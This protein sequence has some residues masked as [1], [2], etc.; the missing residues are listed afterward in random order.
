MP[1]LVDSGIFAVAKEVYGHIG[2]A[3]YGLRTTTMALSLMALLRINRPEGLK[4]HAPAELG[5]VLGLDRA[6]E[7]KT[8]RRKLGQLAALGKAEAFGRKLAERRVARRGRALGFL[9]ADGHIRV[10]HGQRRLPKAHV[11]RMHL[12]LPATT[13]YWVNDKHGDPLFVVTAELNAGLSQMLPVL[14]EEIR[15]LVGPKRRV[16]MVFD[17]GGW[18]PKLFARLIEAGFDILTYRK[19]RWTEIPAAEFAR[20]HARVDGRRVSY[21]LNDRNVRLLKGRLRL[22]QITRLSPD[23]HQTPIVTSRRSLSAAVL[24]YRMFERWRQENFFKYMKEEYALDALA[25]HEAESL[26]AGVTV[27]NPERRKV[28]KELAA[29]HVEL[30]EAQALYGEAASANEEAERPTIRGFKIAH[31]KLGQRIREV[32][33]RIAAIENRRGGMP[34]RV[35]ANEVAGKPIMRLSRER[36]HLTNCMKMVAYQVESD[37]LALLRPHYARADEE[38]RTLVTSALNSAA[39]LE[40]TGDE[41]R[42]TLRPLSSRHRDEAIVGM[43]AAL[44]NMRVYYPGTKLRLWFGVRS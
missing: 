31:G 17:R 41:L 23:G 7:V 3:F 16:T 42:V 10:Y 43:C 35:P 33:G 9:Y 2:P 22:R 4:E 36:K 19:G 28:A 32:Q 37:L 27:V 1:A 8:L 24:A 21:M 30:T 12:S 34:L 20:C 11:T 26:G 6:P 40:V 18:S 15:A 44:N 25:D 39:D 38:G 14:T 29:A 5:R 13:D